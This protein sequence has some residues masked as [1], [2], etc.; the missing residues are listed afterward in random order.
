VL[1]LLLG[2]D[3]ISY[4]C[5]FCYSEKMILAT[6]SIPFLSWEPLNLNVSVRVSRVHSI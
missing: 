3:D 6:Y 4:M 5:C 1:H 2:K